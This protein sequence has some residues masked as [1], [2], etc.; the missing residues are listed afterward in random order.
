MSEID[1][2]ASPDIYGVQE[3][4]YCLCALDIP[5]YDGHNLLQQIII[6]FNIS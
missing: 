3:G 5:Q 4:E 2:V 1:G 6:I